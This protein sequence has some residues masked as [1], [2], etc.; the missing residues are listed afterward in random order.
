MTSGWNEIETVRQG[1]CL[2]GRMTVVPS[3]QM[4]ASLHRTGLGGTAVHTPLAPENMTAAVSGEC[5]HY[6]ELLAS[7]SLNC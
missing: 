3:V 6:L 1:P 2:E 4:W 7:V 5:S